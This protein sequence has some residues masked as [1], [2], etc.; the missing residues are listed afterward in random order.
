MRGNLSFLARPSSL[1]A[2]PTSP[3]LAASPQTPGFVSELRARQIHA[4]EA[5]RFAIV[6]EA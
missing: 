4:L 2:A 1:R 6:G 5:W 3:L